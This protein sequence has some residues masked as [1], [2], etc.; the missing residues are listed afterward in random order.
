MA[1]LKTNY[2]DDVLD[3]SKNEKRKFRMIQNDDGTVSFDDATEYTQQGDAFGAADI[4]ATNAKINEQNQSL[5]NLKNPTTG[6]KGILVNDGSTLTEDYLLV[7]T[8]QSTE[9]LYSGGYIDINGIRVAQ[10]IAQRT[11]C[12][13]TIVGS[14]RGFKGDV[15]SVN[16][17]SFGGSISVYA[18]NAPDI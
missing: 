5:T 11:N 4:N 9:A 16:T 13:L 12:A 17:S 2:K 15:L 10:L 14:V 8:I 1:D 3:T 6:A 7:Y 18:Y